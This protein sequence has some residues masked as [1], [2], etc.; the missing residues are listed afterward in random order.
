MKRVIRPHRTYEIVA[1]GPAMPAAIPLKIKIPAPIMA[2]TPRVV[3]SKR[4]SSRLNFTYAS[5][6]CVSTV[7]CLFIE[8][9]FPFPFRVDGIDL[10]CLLRLCGSL[11]LD[12][13]TLTSG[14]RAAA[15]RMIP[16]EYINFQLGFQS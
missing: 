11:E 9:H 6:P 16:E 5:A 8:H 1:A 2:P 12:Q 10:G 7:L 14:N 13:R 4:P 3:A 15:A